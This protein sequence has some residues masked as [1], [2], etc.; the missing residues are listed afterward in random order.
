MA[1][2]SS[3]SITAV[4]FPLMLLNGEVEGSAAARP[5][6]PEECFTIMERLLELD[7]GEYAEVDRCAA[8]LGEG[9]EEAWKFVRY[10]VRYVPYEGLVRGARGTLNCMSGNSL[11][12]A[13]LLA[14]LLQEKGFRTRLCG[15]ADQG[16]QKLSTE[17]VPPA[18]P[19]PFPSSQIAPLTGVSPEALEAHAAARRASAR[20][21]IAFLAA[22]ARARVKQIHQ[23]LGP[24]TLTSPPAREKG[25][26][27][28]QC[29]VEPGKWLDLDPAGGGEPGK[30]PAEPDLTFPPE[31][32]P[33]DLKTVFTVTVFLNKEELLTIRKSVSELALTAVALGFAPSAPSFAGAFR[34]GPAAV[35]EAFH[36]AERFRPTIIAGTETHLG[37]EFDLK[38]RVFEKRGGG[39]VAAARGIGR[40]LGGLFGGGERKEPEAPSSWEIRYTVKIAGP[41]TRRTVTRVFCESADPETTRVRLLSSVTFLPLPGAVKPEVTARLRLESVLA[42]R[43]ILLA[44]LRGEFSLLRD[45]NRFHAEPMPLL[46]F[47]GAERALLRLLPPQANPFLPFHV[48][49]WEKQADLPPPG[50]GSPRK[51]PKIVISRGIDILFAPVETETNGEQ[52]LETCLRWGALAT[53]LERLI[54]EAFGK[55]PN[56]R[57]AGRDFFL[58]AAKKIPLAAIR[59]EDALKRLSLPKTLEES[60]RR[61]LGAGNF[62]VLPERDPHP[63]PRSPAWGY[64]ALNPRSGELLGRFSGGRGQATSEYVEA[65]DLFLKTLNTIAGFADFMR[66]LLGTIAMPLAG[67]DQAEMRISF[68][69]CFV[70]WA[71]GGLVGAATGMVDVE[72]SWLSIGVGI[73]VEGVGGTD[74]GGLNGAMGKALGNRVC[75]G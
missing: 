7:R 63:G 49:A 2:R 9:W 65:V 72:T 16:P 57:N 10:E 36:K 14:S 31:G 68:C 66:C 15:T 32:I 61:E 46:A 12:Q 56:V 11:D 23:A 3:F 44:A 30:R 74:F 45:W 33:E 52:E 21:S 5:L 13:L 8:S 48:I 1:H 69:K 19:R 25:R 51:P 27:W 59:K 35:A 41:G 42:N 29:E 55:T 38:G 73:G 53:E 60:V 22:R 18:K 50:S 75:G 20:N 54:V 62:V 28:V 26:F 39:R 43:E 64:F 4:L 71:Y 47:A 40:S 34:N 67:A 58:A 6:Q 37:K 70:S 17:P 24:V